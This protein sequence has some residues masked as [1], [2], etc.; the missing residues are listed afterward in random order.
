MSSICYSSYEPTLKSLILCDFPLG[1]KGKK[2][3]DKKNGAFRSGL[4]YYNIK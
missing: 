3:Q 2:S 1:I 4:N